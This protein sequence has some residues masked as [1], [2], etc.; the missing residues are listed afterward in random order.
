M[1]TQTEKLYDHIAELVGR[2]LPNTWNLA[3]ID[4]MIKPEIITAQGFYNQG[5]DSKSISFDIEEDII[6]A[7]DML[8]KEM[9]EQSGFFWQ[10][11]HFELSSD[12]RF[13]FKFDYE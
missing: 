5:P 13:D 10:K 9:Q 11:A 4:L 7:F 1:K 3:W 6:D 8:Q 12:G 2:Q